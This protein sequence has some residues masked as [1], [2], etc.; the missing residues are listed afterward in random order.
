[1]VRSEALKE[2]QKRYRAKQDKYENIKK[3]NTKSNTKRYREDEV[4]REKQKARQR[5]YYARKKEKLKT[6][7]VIEPEEVEPEKT[8]DNEE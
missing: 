8:D 6:N 2:A 4:F 3:I 5:E 1:M 7:E